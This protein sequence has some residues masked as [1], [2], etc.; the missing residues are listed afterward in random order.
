MKTLPPIPSAED[1]FAT[2]RRVLLLAVL[3]LLLAT[4]CTPRGTPDA[5]A[6]GAKEPVTITRTAEG[7]LFAE[8]RDSVL[9][10]RRRA[11]HPEREHARSHYI[12]PLYGAG[13]EV[14]TEDAPADHLH[15][16]GLFWAWHQ[17]LV[18]G[19]RVG[20]GW[21][22]ENVQWDVREVE[23]LEEPASAALQAHVFWTSPTYLNDE[24]QPKPFVE[25]T[26]TIRAYPAAD[27]YREIDVVIKLRALADSV[28]LGGSE[29]EKGYGGFSA[30]VRL[31]EDVRFTGPEGPVT[32]K[33]TAV[34][35]GPWVNIAATFAG[36]QSSG[37]AL[38]QHPSNPDYPQPWIL[39]RAGSMQ[40]AK[41]PGAA[42][43]RL[44]R[45]EPLVL[46]YRLVV[47]QGAPPPLESLHA[48]YAAPSP[49]EPAP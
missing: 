48:R 13:G 16:H 18:G 30:R 25:E 31:P 19:T 43:V 44:P 38:L 26:A 40:N 45:D 17:V 10:Y 33:Q 14:L 37:L 36:E 3:P 28:R 29:D 46:R 34:E 4:G 21:I 27:G 12:H 32:P 5:E 9:L 11:P 49:P 1:A 42:P 15:Q 39:R 22:Q 7:Y 23:V 6:A 41:W 20:D 35:A 2:S 8:G 24:G 47:Y